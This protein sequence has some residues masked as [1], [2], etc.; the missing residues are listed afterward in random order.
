MVLK[1]KCHFELHYQEYCIS[2]TI[3]NYSIAY[4][5]HE[6]SARALFANQTS[7]LAD[8]YGKFS[9]TRGKVTRVLIIYRN[10]TCEKCLK[11]KALLGLWG[12]WKT[13]KKKEKNLPVFKSLLQSLPRT[14]QEGISLFIRKSILFSY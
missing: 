12:R 4:G 1:G 6:A 14:G 2:T 5:S 11:E 13:E 3:G 7:E 10:T 8:I 9:S